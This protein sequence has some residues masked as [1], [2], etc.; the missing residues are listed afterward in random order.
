MVGRSKHDGLQAIKQEA[1][2]AAKIA[3]ALTDRD[4]GLRG[5][6]ASRRKKRHLIGVP[7]SIDALYLW[8]DEMDNEETRWISSEH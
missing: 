3:V 2:A 5:A 4:M 6:E 8:V 7:A 1:T